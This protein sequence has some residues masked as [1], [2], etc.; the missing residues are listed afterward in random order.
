[1]E[2]KILKLRIKE[3][4]NEKG[5]T[6]KELSEKMGKSPQNISNIINGLK[7]IS[8]STLCEIAKLLD[9]E[10]RDLFAVT[11]KNCSEINGYVKVK[12]T[13]YEIHNFDDLE[14]LILLKD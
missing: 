14:K 13:I 7:G 11:G 10:I 6:S 1:M 12:G 9:V 4:L 3:V 2:K 8:L 5:M